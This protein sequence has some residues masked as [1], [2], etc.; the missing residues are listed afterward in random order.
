[1]IVMN[2]AVSMDTWLSRVLS[3][4]EEV[5]NTTFSAA[6]NDVQPLAKVPPAREGSLLPIQKGSESLYLGIL[7][8]P[9]GCVA[10][11]R[12]LLQLD[13][14]EAPGE[15]DVTDAVG[16]IINILAGVVQRSLDGHG[17]AVVLGLPMYI[18]GEIIAPARAEARYA[19]INLGPA[20]A[21]LVVVRG[22]LSGAPDHD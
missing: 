3:A 6:A 11:T 4:A 1:M 9:E 15:A 19:S 22:E 8:D 13:A 7:S 12:A 21:D 2:E 16:E 20:R 5:A 18:R 14:E 17:S 10:L